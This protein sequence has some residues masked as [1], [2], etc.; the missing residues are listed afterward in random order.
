MDDFFILGTV[1]I[2]KVIIEK[3][4]F[5]PDERDIK[6]IFIGEHTNDI[7]IL[8]TKIERGQSLSK[9]EETQLNNTIPYWKTK[10]GPLDDYKVKFINYII[11]TNCITKH[12]ILHILDLENNHNHNSGIGMGSPLQQTKRAHHDG[13]GDGDINT[14]ANAKDWQAIMYS[15]PRVIKYSDIWELAAYIFFKLG[16]KH[17]GIKI[18]D[19]KTLCIQLEIGDISILSTIDDSVIITLEELIANKTF[20]D[21]YRSIPYIH[22]TR[23][24][25]NKEI[26]VKIYRELYSFEC[27]NVV[28]SGE[29][30]DDRVSNLYN[31]SF[32]DQQI[33]LSNEDTRLEDII[34]YSN[35]STNNTLHIILAKDIQDHIK[36]MEENTHKMYTNIRLYLTSITTKFNNI[37]DESILLNTRN[38]NVFLQYGFVNNH[39]EKVL[40]ALV[41]DDKI[42]KSLMT[43]LIHESI[44]HIRDIEQKKFVWTG[45]DLGI[46]IGL[47]LI[48]IFKDIE[49]NIFLPLIKYVSEGEVQLYNI[50]KPFFRNIDDKQ[51]LIYLA[52]KDQILMLNENINTVY[53][54][55]TVK[56]LKYL[57]NLDYLVFKWRLDDTNIMNIYLFETGFIICEF[58]TPGYINFNKSIDLSGITNKILGKIKDKYK[59]NLDLPALNPEKLIKQTPG[60]VIYNDLI[61]INYKITF[62]LIGKLVNGYKSWEQLFTFSESRTGTNILTKLIDKLKEQHNIIILP[63]TFNEKIKFIYTNTY[64]FYSNDNIKHYIRSYMLKKDNKLS[65][66]DRTMLTLNLQ[67][68]FNIDTQTVNTLLTE[69]ETVNLQIKHGLLFHV[70]CE[71]ELNKTEKT[72]KLFVNCEYMNGYE[73]IKNI[74]TMLDALL[75]DCIF[76][77]KFVIDYLDNKS[78]TQNEPGRGTVNPMGKKGQTGQKGIFDLAE[79][80][81]MD[82]A[83]LENLDLADFGD[84]EIADIPMDTFDIDMEIVNKLQRIED[85]KELA[86]LDNQMQ[87][88]DEEQ[89]PLQDIKLKQLVGR[90]EKTSVANYMKNMRRQFDMQLY[91]P[92]VK[93]KKTNFVYESSCPRT[94]MR[95]PFI[96][97]KEQ[98]KQIESEDPESITGYLKYRG[99]YYICPRIWDA[100]ANKPI[101]ARRFIANGLK[102]P[103]TGGLS[104][105]E[106]YTKNLITDK[107][108]VIIRQP[109]SDKYWSDPS[110]YKD[111][112]EALKRTEKDAYPAFTYSTKHP[113]KCTPC[114]GI[115]EPKD[116][117]PSKEVLQ[118]FAKPYNY[119]SCNFKV[120]TDDKKMPGDGK[121][122]DKEIGS[123]CK[124]DDYISNGSTALKNCR[125]GLLPEEL[126]LL[127]NNNQELFLNPTETGIIDGANLFLRRG[128]QYNNITTILETFANILELNTDKLISLII[129]K[130][131][132]L[133]FIELNNGT[134]VNIFANSAE[135]PV[136]PAEHDRFRTFLKLYGP[137]FEYLNIDSEHIVD[138]LES[139]NFDY[140]SQA[141]LLYKMCTSFYNYL[142]YLNSPNEAKNIDYVIDLFA[143][144]RKW[145]PFKSGLNILIFNKTIGQIQCMDTFNYK[146]KQMV[147]LIE[148]EP[149][150]FIP[151]V[152]VI[153]KYGKITATGI[154][155]LNESINLTN[156]L[157]SQLY[158]QK[159]TLTKL[160]ESSKDRLNSII[161]LLYIQSGLCNYNLTNFTSKLTKTIKLHKLPIIKQYQ[162][163]GNSAQV[164]YINIDNI[165]I[166]PVYPTSLISKTSPY[167][168]TEMHTDI[169][170]HD[171][172]YDVY[173][174]RLYEDLIFFIDYG[175]KV[176]E[177]VL[178]KIDNEL[179][180]CGVTFTNGLMV[181]VKPTK[182]DANKF[183]VLRV[184]IY[185]TYGITIRTKQ[186][187]TINLLKINIDNL[188]NKSVTESIFNLLSIYNEIVKSN[189]S[190]YISQSGK[191]SDVTQIINCLDTRENKSIYTLLQH[192]HNILQK[193]ILNIVNISFKAFIS[194]IISSGITKTNKE[195]TRKNIISGNICQNQKTKKQSFVDNNISN[196]DKYELCMRDISTRGK[197]AYNLPKINITTE[198]YPLLLLGIANDLINNHIDSDKIIKGKYIIPVND[199]FLTRLGTGALNLANVNSNNLIISNDELSFFLSRNIIS[200]YK[201]NF[202]LDIDSLEL[203]IISSLSEDE[204]VQ[205]KDFVFKDINQKLTSALGLASIL[206]SYDSSS[207][208]VSSTD[209]EN[210]IISTPFNSNG[211]FNSNAEYGVCKFPFRDKKGK[212]SYKC[213][214]A[215][216]VFKKL[217]TQHIDTQELICPITLNKDKT[218]KTWGY[219]PEKPNVSKQRLQ[220]SPLVDAFDPEN[221]IV[222]L[223]TC[224]FPFIYHNKKVVNPLSGTKPLLKMSFGCEDNTKGTWCYTR[225]IESNRA[226]LIGAIDI[227]NIYKGEWS[228]EPIIPGNKYG[229]VT[230]IGKHMDEINKTVGYKEGMCTFKTDEGEIE[231]IEKHLE[232]D[233]VK[234]ILSL[235]EY[236]PNYCRLGDSKKGYSKKQLYLFGKN[237]LN[238]P[239]RYMLNKHNTILNKPELCDMF[240]IKIRDIKKA[241]IQINQ[242]DLDYS[243]IYT[244]DPMQCKDGETKGGYKFTELRD[245][246]I[247]F[248]GLDEEAAKGMLKDDLCNYIIPIIMGKSVVGFDAESGLK[249]DLKSD[250]KSGIDNN[251]NN[252]GMPKYK[253]ID[254]D[255]IYPP[256]KNINLCSKPIKRDGLSKTEV[257]NIARRYFGIDT[258]GKSKEELCGLIKEGIERIKAEN[259]LIDKQDKQLITRKD[260]PKES[261]VIQL[262]KKIDLLKDMKVDTIDDIKL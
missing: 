132:P 22:G 19:I 234:Q 50:Y 123:Y 55:L 229:P 176:Y 160:I 187:Y 1:S 112:P 221:P 200:K 164:E 182:F 116:F 156:V 122:T 231:K 147:V 166:L 146:S 150:T 179:H 216:S 258:S 118:S 58:Y 183:G 138:V 68:V 85:E 209:K 192:L 185:N 92:T 33:F 201:K 103:Y 215:Q 252:I 161:K 2:L 174:T 27:I 108:N 214:K 254:P 188:R 128:V 48:N 42:S 169:Y 244:K 197:H 54:R 167:D 119:Q 190:Q 13:D 30:R 16:D 233:D 101:S 247:T 205:L 105:L 242:P 131:T 159:P 7:L 125:L 181:S 203:K 163:V 134:L 100:Y 25:F 37:T 17:I 212:I 24:Y 153:N 210:Q 94:A 102:S 113:N 170:K 43:T 217:N 238:I 110:K 193:Y 70:Y 151:I 144:P 223:G 180:V 143:K 225:P 230:S 29:S 77:T 248:F 177:V 145:L 178:D 257:N 15:Y 152:H 61:N 109:T 44:L 207:S 260:M 71:L 218:A 206:S 39:S 149:D 67:K 38:F 65:K 12:L 202:K 41:K 191:H 66:A 232:L 211:I 246:A 36:K 154:I 172:T 124:A 82:L 226:P 196:S 51:K 93:G 255:E 204:L 198:L 236:N 60:N 52:G 79:L 32:D 262:G 83:D 28:K 158:K 157:V 10:F 34:D 63:G 40:N 241:Q 195:Q 165:L 256:N 139:K 74:L 88:D 140:V 64:G 111:W 26:G 97:D 18:K 11:P 46:N 220:Q 227:N 96:I 69:L 189:L 76:D 261:D 23:L 107:Y 99:N 208:R 250:I 57:I 171:L 91:E 45:Y 135:L 155:E 251:A 95:Q 35:M 130:L 219:C 104:I 114:C 120:D 106:G 184:K 20:Q 243:Q 9:E 81:K 31:M 175:Y 224:S 3:H 235:A 6:Y 84:L 8:L 73:L 168:Y 222:K 5:N 98:L 162:G 259:E 80:E 228:M 126:N 240:N 90:K 21:F 173:I 249:S 62:D 199:M 53:D 115:N 239:Y 87:K 127:M 245:M 78:T 59:L 186:Q 148:E 194:S 86:K 213:A 253:Y 133:E 75:K 4:R 142:G 237:I 89:Q 14:K 49:P 137:L 141:K 47:D 121:D 56:R 136:S 129:N 72:M 117:D